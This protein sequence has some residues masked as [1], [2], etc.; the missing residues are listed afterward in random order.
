[1]NKCNKCGEQIM[2]FSG[3]CQI[4]GLDNKPSPT[5]QRLDRIESAIRELA[6]LAENLRIYGHNSGNIIEVINKILGGEDHSF[7]DSTF[8]Y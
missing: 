4:C 3:I 5:D 2:S 1:M 6:T 7:E 8:N